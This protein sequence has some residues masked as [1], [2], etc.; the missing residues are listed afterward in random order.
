MSSS[1]SMERSSTCSMGWDKA[2][3]HIPRRKTAYQKFVALPQYPT[4]ILGYFDPDAWAADPNRRT[5]IFDP[6]GRIKTA[7]TDPTLGVARVRRAG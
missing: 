2:T 3:A 6:S 4:I 1:W 5:D 7:A